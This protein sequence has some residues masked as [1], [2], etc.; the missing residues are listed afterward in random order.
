MNINELTNAEVLFIYFSNEDAIHSINDI[1]EHGSTIQEI[2]LMG[3]TK[4]SVEMALSPEELSKIRS[5]VRTSAIESI[6]RKLEPIVQMIKEADSDLYDS[7]L[8]NE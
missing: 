5:S 6:Q 2:D 4:I 8:K 7:F 1:L 3:L